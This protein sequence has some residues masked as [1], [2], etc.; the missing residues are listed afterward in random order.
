MREGL[1][2]CVSRNLHKRMLPG[3]ITVADA[4]LLDGRCGTVETYLERLYNGEFVL[5]YWSSAYQHGGNTLEIRLLSLLHNCAVEVYLPPGEEYG[6][7]GSMP[8]LQALDS[9]PG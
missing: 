5:P 9:R 8:H 2:R 7:W 3:G 6:Q 1:A 4:V